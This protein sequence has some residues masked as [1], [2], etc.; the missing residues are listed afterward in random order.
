MNDLVELQKIAWIILR[1]WWLLIIAVILGSV[2]GYRFSRLQ[3]PVY[4]ATTIILVGQS[5]QSAQLDSR[6]ITASEQLARTYATIAKLQPVLQSVVQSL[7][8]DTDWQ[9]L[10]SRV[11]T[12][13]LE[14]TQLLRITVEA[15]S[16]A[17]ALLIADEI[18]NTLVALSPATLQQQD[19]GE[20]E[21]F[22]HRRLDKLGLNILEAQT[23]IDTLQAQI[24]TARTTA[25]LKTLQQEIEAIETLLIGWDSNYARFQDL[26]K[27]QGSP[28]YLSVVEP[29]QAA[30]DPVRPRTLLNVLIVG[31]AF[32]VVAAGIVIVVDFSDESITSVGALRQSLGIESLGAIPHIAG[33]NETDKLITCKDPLSRGAEAYA[34]MRSNIFL[35]YGRRFPKSIAVISPSTGEGKSL[36][37]VNLAVAIAQAGFKTIIVDTNLMNP[38]LHKFFD[39]SDHEGLLDML[40]WPGIEIEHFLKDTS[41]RDLR[42]LTSGAATSVPPKP[43]LYR[44][45]HKEKPDFEHQRQVRLLSHTMTSHLERIVADLEQL[46][47]VV[48]F[49]SPALLSHADATLLSGYVDGIVMV[50]KS[51]R[52]RA[53][54]ARQ[55]IT[56]LQ[57][58][59]A[60]LLGVV[61]NKTTSEVIWHK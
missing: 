48:V 50:V 22:L 9:Q 56:N 25:E 24:L 44:L 5:M 12:T 2:S 10:R 8:L 51:R 31:L 17:E 27:A 3:T 13:P 49:D 39:V 55:A 26:T 28:N 54:K 15:G 59:G 42:L 30:S 29:A 35:K 53:T 43:Y 52:T 46:A 37:A 14:Q 32:F 6:D 1:W 40:G 36:T 41:I 18:A 45:T 21:Q 23:R 47:D 19:A 58:A 16:S 61:L 11:R 34:M 20:G 7:N 60:T 57:Q 4:E 33:K 38:V